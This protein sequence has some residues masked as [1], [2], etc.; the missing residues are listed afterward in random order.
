M[1]RL[2][3][4]EP[5]EEAEQRRL[6]APRG[7]DH[8]DVPT[9]LDG[10]RD[11]VQDTR[12]RA[13][14]EVHMRESELTSERGSRARVRAVL[15]LRLHREHLDDALGRSERLGPALDR[16]RRLPKRAVRRAQIADEDDQLSGGERSSQHL[17]RSEREHHGDSRRKRQL[18]GAVHPRLQPGRR[19][20]LFEA[21]P[22]DLVEAFLLAL[23]CTV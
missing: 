17:D 11:V 2:R 9:G 16:L 6:T 1:S 22:V 14:G 19:D 3:I 23:A 7:P 12:P 20:A 13:V 18:D 21:A 5:R 15:Q 8:R 10:E 4:E